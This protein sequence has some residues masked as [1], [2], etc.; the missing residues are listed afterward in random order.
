[1]A[2]SE[3][4]RRSKGEALPV[5]WRIST[6][7]EA[8]LGRHFW[9]RLLGV[10]SGELTEEMIKEYLSHHLKKTPTTF[11]LENWRAF[12]PVSGLSVH[13]IEPSDFSRR[14]FS[15]KLHIVNW[16]WTLFWRDF[17]MKTSFTFTLVFDSQIPNSRFQIWIAKGNFPLLAL[18]TVAII[19]PARGYPRFD[20]L[21]NYD[22]AWTNVYDGGETSMVLWQTISWFK[23]IYRWFEYLCWTNFR[24]F[25]AWAI[26]LIRPQCCIIPL[27]DL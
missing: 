18:L 11:E 8:L 25:G 19:T 6:Y 4:M 5:V 16:H 14:L 10:T 23:N 27:V 21:V 1:M 20:T 9:A 26:L 24:Y 13:Q 12:L 17:L 2:P 7:Q 15:W 3:I 22:T